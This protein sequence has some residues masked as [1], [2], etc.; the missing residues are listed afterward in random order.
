MSQKSR[1]LSPIRGDSIT[2]KKEETAV[3]IVV[4][5]TIKIMYSMKRTLF[6]D[7]Y[8][9]TAMPGGMNFRT[10]RTGKMSDERMLTQPGAAAS[11][12]HTSRAGETAEEDFPYAFPSERTVNRK[13]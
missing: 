6:P 7:T 1:Y 12:K 4:A 11:N 9:A 13:K 10:F 5:L 2:R 8:P 3:R